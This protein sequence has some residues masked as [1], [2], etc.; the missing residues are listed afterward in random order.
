MR[1]TDNAELLRLDHAEPIDRDW[2]AR[3]GGELEFCS[4]NPSVVLGP[5]WS[6]DYSASVVIVKKLLLMISG[7]KEAGGEVEIEEAGAS[8]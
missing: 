2:V 6:R 8:E 4:I 5:V 7:E 3:E 1:N